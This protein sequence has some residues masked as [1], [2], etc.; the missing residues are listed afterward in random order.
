MDNTLSSTILFCA[1]GNPGKKY[2]TTR[3]NIGFIF[4]DK[5]AS[6]YSL[7]DFT[8]CSKI[9]GFIS[10]GR[11]S[12]KDIIIVKPDTYMNLSGVSV[13]AAVR[14]FRI[15]EENLF[16]VHDDIDLKFGTERIRKN[17]SDA[18][19][20]GIRSIIAEIGTEN[21]NRIRLGVGKPEKMSV[22]DYVLSNFIDEELNYI[23]T[24]WSDK[25]NSIANFIIENGVSEA[26]NVFN[27]KQRGQV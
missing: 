2:F 15:S 9:K 22:P 23:N 3:H 1:L 10:S 24:V 27:R 26:M 4:A 25:W 14:M 5:I 18:G 17:G 13:S 6:H 19:H 21:F 8:Y 20:K 11:I 7:N 16:A 12:G